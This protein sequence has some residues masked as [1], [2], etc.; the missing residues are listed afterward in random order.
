MKA[1]YLVAPKQLELRVNEP[2]PEVVHADDVLIRIAYSGIC[3]WD[4]RVFNGKKQVPLPRILGH[5]STGIVEAV[6]SAVTDLAPGVPVVADFIVKCGVCP[7]CRTGRG[8]VCRQPKFLKGG[9]EEYV[10]V[11]RTNVYPLLDRKFLKAAALTEPL[12][13]VVHGQNALR[14][15]PGEV[16]II[17]GAGPIGLMHMQT[18]K[19]HGCRT[20]VIDVLQSRL[21]VA[22][23]LGADFC[24]DASKEDQRER[25]G[26]ITGTVMADA[27]VVTVPSTAVVRSC[28]D[29]LGKG[30]RLNIFAGIYPQDNLVIDPNMIHYNELCL[31][32]SADSTSRDFYDALGL[33]QHGQVRTEELVSTLVTLETLD[34]GFRIVN[35]RAGLKIV[36]KIAGDD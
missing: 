4:V 24:I 17:V 16:E 26:Q 15:T 23:S 22:A 36:C 11:P 31:T 20:I 14:L 18:A 13:C 1:V 10:V 12:A 8:N 19:A 28:M 21:D 25:V 35:D 32:G 3:P 6:G 7:A 30:G 34:E 2:K 5:E 9:F 33:I 27:A 29:L